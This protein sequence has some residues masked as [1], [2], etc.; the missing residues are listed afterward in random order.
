MNQITIVGTQQT[1]ISQKVP[2]IIKK[3]FKNSD[4]FRYQNMLA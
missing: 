1:T 2:I 3:F 4:V